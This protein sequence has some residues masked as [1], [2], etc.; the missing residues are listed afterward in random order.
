M[1]APAG[2]PSQGSSGIGDG[3]RRASPPALCERGIADWRQGPREASPGRPPEVF[4]STS[5]AQDLQP[6]PWSRRGLK[7]RSASPARSPTVPARRLRDAEPNTGAFSPKLFDGAGLIFEPYPA[8]MAFLPGTQGIRHSP[9][10]SAASAG[11]GLRQARQAARVR[12]AGRAR[13]HGRR[14]RAC[15]A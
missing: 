8:G 10:R 14:C 12:Y 1:I 6:L 11:A 13:S 7:G 15:R 9:A 3:A 5:N 4:A 2:G